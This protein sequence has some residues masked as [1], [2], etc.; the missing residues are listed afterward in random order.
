MEEPVKSEPKPRGGRRPGAGRPRG[1]GRRV[2]KVRLEPVAYDDKDIRPIALRARDFTGLSLKTYVDCLKS[3]DASWGDKIRAADALLARGYGKPMENVNVT[4]LNSFAGLSD[5]DI[6]ATL[7]NIR[8]ALSM[9]KR[10]DAATDITASATIVD[11]V[12][13]V[14]GV[15]ASE[16]SPP[17]AEPAGSGSE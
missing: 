13:G 12:G 17:D 8:A 15:Q 5:G 7:A 3:K 10:S 2:I 14:S 4:S 11:S 1:G 9:G 6:A 16:A